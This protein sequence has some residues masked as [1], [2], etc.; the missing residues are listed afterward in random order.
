MFT[1]LLALK[2]Y[3]MEE[4]DKICFMCCQNVVPLVG[5]VGR[6]IKGI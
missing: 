3:H 6:E 2:G 1:I 5:V 4:R